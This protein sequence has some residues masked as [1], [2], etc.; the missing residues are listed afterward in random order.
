M[1]NPTIGGNKSAQDIAGF[2]A[3]S[4][5]QGPRILPNGPI[6]AFASLGTSAVHVAGTWYRSEIYVPHL[7]QW[8]GINVLNGA[9]VGTDNIL[10]ALYDT[11]GVLIT[12]SAVAGAL[13]GWCQCTFQSLAFLTRRSNYRWP[14]ISSGGASATERRSPQRKWAAANGGNQMTQSAT[15]TLLRFSGELHSSN[16]LTRRRWANRYAVLVTHS[17]DFGPRFRDHADSTCTITKSGRCDT[18]GRPA[19]Q[20]GLHVVG[21]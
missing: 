12:N 5:P 9:T 7:A 16:D 2:G 13:S 14:G 19:C 20:A 10:V 15:G 1:L 11:N 6:L 4:S 17:G 18:Y 3:P 21:R 8:T